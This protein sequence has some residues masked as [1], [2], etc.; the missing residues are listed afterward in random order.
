MRQIREITV[1]LFLV[2]SLFQTAMTESIVPLLARALHNI[3]KTPPRIITSPPT[4]TSI[5]PTTPDKISNPNQNLVVQL[6]LS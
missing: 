5:I 2:A 6:S 3:R 4:R 1:F